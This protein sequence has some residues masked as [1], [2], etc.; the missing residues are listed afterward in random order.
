[1][2]TLDH[3]W[4]IQTPFRFSE[5]HLCTIFKYSCLKIRGTRSIDT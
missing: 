1:M 3:K 5:N 4:N 2:Y